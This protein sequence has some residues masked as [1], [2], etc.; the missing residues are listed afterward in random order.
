MLFMF[1][2]SFALFP[3]IFLLVL[4]FII[5]Q[6]LR[7]VGESISNSQKPR[8]TVHVQVLDKRAHVWFHASFRHWHA[9]WGRLP[10]QLLCDLPV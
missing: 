1:E 2:G 10:H 8:E 5:F 7:N 9:P 6:I 4:G 3:I